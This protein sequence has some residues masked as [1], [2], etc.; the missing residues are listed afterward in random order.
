M[1][2]GG[3]VICHIRNLIWQT[4]HFYI[5]TLLGYEAHIKQPIFSHSLSS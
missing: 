4:L 3:N 5:G 2:D 1:V